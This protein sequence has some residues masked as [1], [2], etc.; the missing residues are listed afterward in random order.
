MNVSEVEARVAQ[1]AA[2]GDDDPEQAHH[3]EDELWRD[4]L[5]A[6]ADGAEHPAELA[7]AAMK[8]WDPERIRWYA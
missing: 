5:A 4:V 6:I 3:L 2:I 8:V 7:A 1:V